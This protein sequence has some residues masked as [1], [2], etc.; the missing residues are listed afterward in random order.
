MTDTNGLCVLRGSGNG[1][2]VGISAHKEGYYWSSGYREQ[3]TNLVGVADRRWE[4]WNPTV[5]VTLVRIGSPRPMYAKMLRD[6]PIPDEGG[7]VGFDLS[8]GDWVAPHGGGKHGDL[9][10]HYE[11]KPEGT[12]STRYGP[13]QTY[14]YSL[15]ISTSNE[16]D[17][18]L[19]VS[20]PLRGGHSALRLPKQAPKDGYVPTRTMRVY[21]DR[22]MQSHSDIRE[23]R[24]YFLRV[25]TRKD[26]DGNIVSALYGK[27]HGD[28]TFDHSGRLSFTYYL[29]PEPNEQNVEFDPTENLFRNLSSLQDVREP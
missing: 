28:F 29:N 1:G 15:T 26:E 6:I 20:S 5:D 25:R 4:P 12:I 21:R 8:A 18:L 27:I 17:G 10:F 3:F 9:V 19:A 11:S 16:S 23:D 7:P 24:N 2:A 22:D 14:D 13:V